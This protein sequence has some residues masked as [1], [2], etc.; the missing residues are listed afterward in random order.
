MTTS[1]S[2]SI[3]RA[4]DWAQI[5]QYPIRIIW[6]KLPKK[7][8]PRVPLLP[9]VFGYAPNYFKTQ[10]HWWDNPHQSSSKPAW[11]NK[12]DKLVSCCAF[13]IAL[14]LILLKL[15]LYEVR[16]P[17]SLLGDQVSALRDALHLLKSSEN[18]LLHYG[19]EELEK[20]RKRQEAGGV[21]E[22]TEEEGD[23][24]DEGQ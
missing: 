3:A 5:N 9:W 10:L 24:V 20:I 6:D 7:D 21:D 11:W 14:L 13:S 4:L 23:G 8:E 2:K 22:H 17:R 19:N 15:W 12:P 1:L 16:I 18:I